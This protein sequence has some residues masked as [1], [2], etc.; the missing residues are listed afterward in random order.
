MGTCGL[1]SGAAKVGKAAGDWAAA[2]G[3]GLEVSPSGCMGYCPAEPIMDVVTAGGQRLS[4]G[5]VKP[6]DTGF[7]LDEVLLRNN[8][9]L[10]GLLGQQRNGREPL[11]GVSFVDEHPFFRKQVKYVLRNCGVVNPESLAEYREHGGFLGLEKAL[12]MTP[13]QVVASVAA[14][15]LRG[16]GGAGFPT[17]RKWQLAQGETAERKFMICNADEGDP[18]AFMDRSLLEGDPFAVIEGM[19]IAGYAIGALEGILYCRAEYPLAIKRVEK[20][21]ETLKEEGLL[22]RELTRAGGRP[23]IFTLRIKQGAGAFVCGEETA[24]IHS[25]EGKRGMPRPRPPYPS[26]SGLFGCPTVINNVETLAN[27]PHILREGPESLAGMG[28]ET[29]KGT[30]VFA[31]TGKITCAGLV[32]VPMGIT[33][34]EIIYDIGGGIPGGKA[35]KAVQSGGP[36]GGCIPGEHLDTRIDYESLKAIGAMMG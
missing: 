33:L 5:N 25:I 18:G 27:V 23:F 1:A 4:F 7:I 36:S 9:R 31:L 32:E 21:I 2:H 6:E 12:S 10:D 8:H 29:S 17:G 30:K 35:F 26:V 22:E 20:A 24:L 16:R 11:A 13:A 34:R 19:M 28:T 3:V 15:G 14:S